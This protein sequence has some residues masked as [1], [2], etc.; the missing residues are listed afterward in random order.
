MS[1]IKIG[2]TIYARNSFN[3]LCLDDHGD[4]LLYFY[5]KLDPVFFEKLAASKIVQSCYLK[6]GYNGYQCSEFA[7]Y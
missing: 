1:W 4:N 7:R 5:N 6:L 2:V 3:R